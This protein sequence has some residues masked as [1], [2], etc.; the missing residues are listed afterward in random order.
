MN[1]PHHPQVADATPIL[2]RIPHPIKKEGHLMPPAKPNPA[3]GKQ[4]ANAR[5]KSYTRN[6]KKVR[7]HTRS[8]NATRIKATWVGTATSGAV[9]VGILLEAGFTIASSLGVVLI[10]SFTWLAVIAG[11][12]AEKNRAT[13]NAQTKKRRAGRR[14]PTARRTT[15]SRTTNNTRRR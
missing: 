13:M 4:P 14:K 8:V 5:W 15:R 12:W 2:L 11:G 3:A 6:G 9:C 1:S 7:G 10:A